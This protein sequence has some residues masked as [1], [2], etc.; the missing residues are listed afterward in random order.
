MAVSAAESGTCG[1]GITWVYEN[2]TLTISG[3]GEM[4]D[5]SGGAPWAA[6]KDS[7][8][9]VII[10]DGIAKIGAYAFQNYDNIRSV[11]FGN[12]LVEI[13]AYAFQGCDGLTHISLPSGFKVFGASSFES[14]KNLRTIS[15]AGRCPRFEYNS[16]WDV[17]GVI[18]YPAGWPWKLETMQELEKAFRG[19]INFLASDGSDPEAGL[20][21]EEETIGETTGPVETTI[22][23]TGETAASTEALPF[24]TGQ[25]GPVTDRDE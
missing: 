16:M 20:E 14:C 21:E 24:P 22:L 25:T 23:P 10:G 11:T 1:E 12:G 3:S 5:C 17:N 19:R 15:C 18:Y 4:A 6:H 7:I 2:G 13:G 8:T 9:T